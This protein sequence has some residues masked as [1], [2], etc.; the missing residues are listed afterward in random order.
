LTVHLPVAETERTGPMLMSLLGAG[1][2]LS[3]YFHHVTT[4][5]AVTGVPS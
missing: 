4:A 1:N 2:W 5:C 3:T